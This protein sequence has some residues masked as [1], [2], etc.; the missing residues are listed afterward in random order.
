MELSA[1]R[2]SR[3]SLATFLAGSAGFLAFPPLA[4]GELAVAE[5]KLPLFEPGVGC[6]PDFETGAADFDSGPDR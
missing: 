5:L 6:F 3:S 4:V 2:I 1:E